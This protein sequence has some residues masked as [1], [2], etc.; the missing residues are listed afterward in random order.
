MGRFCSC[1]ALILI[2][3]AAIGCAKS[4][5]ADPETDS[6]TDPVE[7][8]D[9]V[10][11]VTGRVGMGAAGKVRVDIYSAQPRKA[12]LTVPLVSTQTNAYGMFEA[13]LAAE[14][15][16]QSIVIKASFVADVSEQ[17]CLDVSGC[18]DQPFGA[19]MPT[20]YPLTLYTYVPKVSGDRQ[21]GVTVITDLIYDMMTATQSADEPTAV[22]LAKANS[23]F[24]SRMGIVGQMA[25]VP[26]VDLSSAV[27]VA[28]ADAKALFYSALGPAIVQSAALAQPNLT[29]IELIASFKSRFLNGGLANRS[30][31]AEQ[32]SLFNIYQQAMDLLEIHKQDADL[33]SLLTRLNA[34]R[35]L[36]EIEPTDDA[37]S[38]TDSSYTD[39]IPVERA[40]AFVQ[41]IRQIYFS[42]NLQKFSVFNDLSGFVSGDALGVLSAIGIDIDAAPLFT[43]D[44]TKQLTDAFTAVAKAMVDALIA[45]LTAETA[46]AVT[47]FDINGITI[48]IA[49]VGDKKVLSV[50]QYIDVCE[51]SGSSCPV[52]ADLVVAVAV[53]GIGGDPEFGSYILRRVSLSLSGQLSGGGSVIHFDGSEPVLTAVGFNLDITANNT[54]FSDSSNYAIRLKDLD[55]SLPFR[56]ESNVA[57]GLYR[58]TS[59][60]TT[61]VARAELE[62][63]SVEQRS[64]EADGIF[65][66]MIE[67]KFRILDIGEGD[68][69]NLAAKIDT[70]DQQGFT[71]SISLRKDD[72]FYKG[73][74]EYVSNE[75]QRCTAQAQPVCESET[76]TSGMQGESAEEFLG[77][78]SVAVY[79]ANLKGVAEPVQ[80]EIA[81]SRATNDAN[82]IDRMKV[83]YPA[84]AFVLSG[85]FNRL[86]GVDKLNA[87]SLDGV[88][89]IIDKESGSRFGFVE[90][91]DKT[92]M[93]KIK[94][95]GTELKITFI[96]GVFVGM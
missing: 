80:M 79:K 78:N 11:T 2:T 89:L 30:A 82:S 57:D 55:V 20:Q 31:D 52:Y 48:G 71:T 17:R 21:Y 73:T 40:K 96:D 86:G 65:Y 64:A 81:L 16:E 43:G 41:D 85:E 38:G 26:V 93:A 83:S 44:G 8:P 25:E 60:V 24:A 12:D 58:L 14:Y 13:P 28:T 7:S 94:D 72:N 46:G 61:K 9:K 84:H 53:S 45:S 95:M 35:L 47:S 62:Y 15:A 87:E 75:L 92:P 27:E 5:L 39:L 66:K 18:G 37:Q 6:P 63:S 68:Y 51:V 36:F 32:L 70:P 19:A 50:Q 67:D 90:D 4:R 59:V 23:R 49:N 10:V 29:D 77:L 76:S 34:S 3:I 42:L 91:F 69:I 33:G 22:T 54:S 74:S 56:L 1:L 88:R